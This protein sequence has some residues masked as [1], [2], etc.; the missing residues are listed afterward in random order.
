MG[1]APKA[2]DPVKTASAQ[3]DYNTGAG[4]ASGIINNPNIKNPYGEVNYSQSGTEKITL[5]NG[6]IVE[7]PRYTQTTTPNA[8]AQ[9]QINQRNALV[10]QL[11]GQNAKTLGTDPTKGAPSWQ[12]G[13][14]AS[15]IDSGYKSNANTLG[16]M[17]LSGP[18][19]QMYNGQVNLGAY[20]PTNNAGDLNMDYTPEGGFSEDRRRVEE[21]TMGRA[22]ELLTQNRDQEV[23]RLAAM[24]LAPGGEK[25]GRVSDQFEKS[26]NDLAL[27]S[28]LA[29]GQEQSRLLGE[30][31]SAGQFHNDAV[32]QGYGMEMGTT[33]ANN[34]RLLA[35]AGFNR[36]TV[37]QNNAAKAAD[38]QM[39]LAV[40]QMENARRT[41]DM[42]AY[43]KAL[44][45]HNNAQIQK[46]Q[47]ARDKATFSNTTRSA[48]V[49]E[50]Q[51]KTNTSLNQLMALLGGTQFQNP[52]APSYQ[53][54]GVQAPDYS[55][56]V[57]SNYGQQVGQY[58]NM[59]SGLASL[60]GAFLG[61][62]AKSIF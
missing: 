32:G 53:G 17:G 46:T 8:A 49:N 26:A 9:K 29:G 16:F 12:S 59:M 41:G 58:N 23:A 19:Q 25:Y 43:N 34:D 33:Q 13:Y 27:Q 56:L 48:M 18:T 39:Q 14:T 38:R 31:R 2:P 60:G 22:G 11:M 20:K 1:S 4:I 21:A 24:G 44:E 45:A 54:Q 28:V 57:S 55:G 5:P 51:S 50:M 52:N 61:P 7:V 42:E 10:N 15:P 62:F 35:Q 40:T 36:D 37:A 30:A 6:Q 47:I 3:F